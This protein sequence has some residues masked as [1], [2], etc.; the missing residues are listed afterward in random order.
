MTSQLTRADTA[1][2]EPASRVRLLR[3]A[4]TVFETSGYSAARVADIVDVA[5]LSHGSFYSY[6]PNKEMIFRALADQVVQEIGAAS[7]STYRGSD[8]RLRVESSNRN[9]LAAFRDNA[10]MMAV[11]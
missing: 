9:Y 4:R 2:A 11:V 1:K 3:A 8:P 6:F 5:G 10:R 7:A